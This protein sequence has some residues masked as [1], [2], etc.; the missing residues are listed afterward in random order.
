MLCEESV[1]SLYR[2]PGL[3]RTK[4]EVVSRAT[5][6]F[7]SGIQSKITGWDSEIGL[8]PRTAVPQSSGFDLLHKT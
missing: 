6:K 8:D 4:K 3:A 7:R 1:G 5:I 2:D